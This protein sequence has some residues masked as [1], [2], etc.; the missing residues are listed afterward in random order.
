MQQLGTAWPRVAV[1]LLVAWVVS[2][3]AAYFV[4]LLSL[5]VG[6]LPIALAMVVWALASIAVTVVLR[7]RVAPA[8]PEA[9]AARAGFRTFPQRAALAANGAL[10]VGGLVL[11]LVM[12]VGRVDYSLRFGA[13]PGLIAGVVGGFLLLAAVAPAAVVNALWTFSRRTAAVERAVLDDRLE[14]DRPAIV[15]AR[16]V[17]VVAW[18]A[19]GSLAVLLAVAAGTGVI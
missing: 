13:A 4:V 18:A 19:Y 9:D 6:R 15:R 3:P 12:V 11:V 17:A 14:G 16:V 7:L 1:V 8:E 2:G 5:G 10:L